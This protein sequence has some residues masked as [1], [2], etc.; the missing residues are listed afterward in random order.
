MKILIST[1]EWTQF[2]YYKSVIQALYRK[3][4]TVRILFAKEENP[5]VMEELNAMKKES[6]GLFDWAKSFYVGERKGSQYNRLRAKRVVNNYRHFLILK[7]KGY[8]S[9]FYSLRLRKYFPW[10]LKP[11]FLTENLNLN[12]FMKSRV[13]G[14]FLDYIE[15]KTPPDE[16][17]VQQI[18]D[19]MPDAVIVSP[20]DIASST[21]DYDYVSAAQ[22]LKIPAILFVVS[23][24]NLE[25]KGRIQRAPDKLFVWN[26]IQAAAA[27]NNHNISKESIQIVGAPFY[28]EF[29]SAKGPFS[30]REEF[31]NRFGFSSQK[32]ILLYMGSTPIYTN[33]LNLFNRF[34]MALKN[35]NDEWVKS[36]QFIVRPHPASYKFFAGID[37]NKDASV[38]LQRGSVP[39]NKEAL[40]TLYDTIYYSEA[41]IGVCTSGFID[42]FILGKPVI[43]M[44]VD[45]Y[46]HI[47]I[48]APHCRQLLEGDVLDIASNLGDLP[49][50]LKRL[51]A[52]KD[53]RKIL[54]ENFIKDYVRPNGIETSAG[55]AFAVALERLYLKNDSSGYSAILARN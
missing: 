1:E 4:H 22:F 24:D 51:N 23:W 27:I 2:I 7:E 47:Q 5:R 40:K 33:E 17:I 32:P 44:L 48:Q 26:K 45:E 9:S 10:W 29:L 25:T 20:G 55:E 28:D 12:F 54:R 35:S 38:A 21:P 52:G 39:E 18:K 14:R 6:D 42:A 37:K 53:D 41:V 16:Q 34:K 46:T 13:V 3:G 49:G 19:F 31:C 15:Y 8:L 50:I 11:F 30:S 36:M 43:T